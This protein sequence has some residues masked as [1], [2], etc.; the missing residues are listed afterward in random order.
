M[1]LSRIALASIRLATR[2]WPLP[3]GQGAPAHLGAFATRIGMLSPEWYEFRP[4]LWMQLNV[5][6]LV[7]QTILLEGTWDPSLTSFIETTLQPGDVFIDVG[8]HV[9]Y[10]TLL[11]A[12]RVGPSGAVLSVEPNPIAMEQLSRNVSRSGLQNVLAAHTACGDSHDPVRLYLH[13]ESNTS[14]ASL[15][16]ANATSGVAVDVSCTPLDD[17]C[18]ERGLDRVRLVKIDVEGAELSVLRSMTRLLRHMKPIVVLEL[19]PRLLTSFGTTSDSVVAFLTDHDYRVAPLGGHS[20]YV[21]H[22]VGGCW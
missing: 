6:D 14:M 9:G 7:Q 2:L 20:N 5:R 19:E 18:M 15:S 16:S 13:T 1:S 11:A 10:F 8:A 4:G 12:S 21:C 17:L 3:F 22:P